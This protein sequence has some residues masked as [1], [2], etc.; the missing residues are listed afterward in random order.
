MSFKSKKSQEEQ[1]DKSKSLQRR[2]KRTWSKFPWVKSK[3]S[4]EEQNGSSKILQRRVRSTGS[5]SLWVKSKW[6]GHL[7]RSWK[8]LDEVAAC[9]SNMA[10]GVH[11]KPSYTVVDLGPGLQ[12][13]M[14]PRKTQP[15]LVSRLLWAKNVMFRAAGY[16]ERRYGRSVPPDWKFHEERPKDLRCMVDSRMKTS[17]DKDRTNQ[18]SRPN[19]K[20]RLDNWSQMK[21]L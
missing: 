4:Q 7:Q 17:K 12:R 6:K 1:N 19:K 9:V 5:K 21:E 14:I 15:A 16:Q 8:I 20:T 3:K 2:V 18:D 11:F 13:G 10:I